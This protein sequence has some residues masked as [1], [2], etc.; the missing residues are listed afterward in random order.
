MKR[1]KH[2]WKKETGIT[3][4]FA[5]ER[6]K[7]ILGRLP[8]MGYELPVKTEILENQKIYYPYGVGYGSIKKTWYLVNTS[9][10]LSISLHESLV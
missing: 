1:Y 2:N 9:G 6:S 5:I 7:E 10:S 8:K 3:L 4:K